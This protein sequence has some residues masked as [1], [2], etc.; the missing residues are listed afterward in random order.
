MRGARLV[1]AA[2]LLI[3]AGAVVVAKPLIW[4]APSGAA[5][6]AVYFVAARNRRHALAALWPILF[7]AFLLILLQKAG[8]AIDWTL[9][10]KTVT[11]FALV[12]TAVRLIPWTELLRRARPSSPAFTLFLFA[13]LVRHFVGILGA[14]A[15][16]VMIAR[17]QAVPARY[18]R[19]WFRSLTWAAAAVFRRS[20]ERAERFY[21]AQSLRGL[22]A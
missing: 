5:A 12:L 7:F 18:G 9:P 2:I 21:A 4:L 6:V 11:I 15:M 20:L 19:G 22:D 10:V 1:A 8:G 16:R 13:L 3:A 17:R 14:E